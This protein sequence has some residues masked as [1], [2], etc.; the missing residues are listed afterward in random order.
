[1]VAIYARVSTDEQQTKQQIFECEEFCKRK[2]WKW[3]VFEEKESAKGVHRV[4]LQKM[5]GMVERGRFK[6]V[7]VWKIDRLTRSIQDF[8]WVWKRLNDSECGLISVTQGIDTGNNDA[9]GRMLVNMLVVFAEWE[10]D[11]IV[12]RTKAGLNR[13][14]REGKV[15]GRKKVSFDLVGAWKDWKKK[16][17]GLRELGEKYGVSHQTMAVRL[18]EWDKV[19]EEGENED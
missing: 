14:K 4:E 18:K 10:R 3:R 9:N 8:V 11:M 6:N 7:V 17:M 12:E 1:M 2:G 15:L 13:A 5:L 19:M 16:G